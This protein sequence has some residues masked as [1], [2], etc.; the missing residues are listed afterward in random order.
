M[1]D[2]YGKK[3][4][5]KVSA[6]ANYSKWARKGER[7]RESESEREAEYNMKQMP[8]QMGDKQAHRFLNCHFQ[9]ENGNCFCCKVGF[10]A[11]LV[12]LVNCFFA[13]VDEWKN[14]Q[15]NLCRTPFIK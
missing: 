1:L 4:I 6:N 9:W 7:Q 8:P 12:S 14:L 15:Q 10:L 5:F 13:T 3:N 2:K 11:C